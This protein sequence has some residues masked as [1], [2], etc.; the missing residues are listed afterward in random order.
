MVSCAD[1]SDISSSQE[2]ITF[3]ELT[4]SQQAQ[5]THFTQLSEVQKE[6]RL[7][8]NGSAGLL[9]AWWVCTEQAD[10]YLD[11]G[12]DDPEYH[13]YVVECVVSALNEEQ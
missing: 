10:A 11:Y 8:K 2:S 3:E 9:W 4:Q 1:N 7:N 12:P 5:F 13:S 6:L